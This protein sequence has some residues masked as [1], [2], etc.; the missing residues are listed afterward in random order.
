MLSK[1]KLGKHVYTLNKDPKVTLGFMIMTCI[2]KLNVTEYNFSST[3]ET[4]YNPYLAPK[5]VVLS[6]SQG[7]LLSSNSS[8]PT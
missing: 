3:D 1:N 7:C 8:I 2:S 5:I 6:I 4:E